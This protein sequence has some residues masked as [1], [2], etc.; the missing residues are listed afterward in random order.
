MVNNNIYPSFEYVLQRVATAIVNLY[1]YD[2]ELLEVDANERSITHKLAEHLQKEFPEWHVDCEYNRRGFDTKKLLENISFPTEN[3]SSDDTEARTV[4]PDIIVHKRTT[5]LN[6]LVIEVKK[7]NNNDSTIDIQKLM[8]F[9]HDQNYCY[10]FGLFVR[11]GNSGCKEVRLFEEGTEMQHE[12]S[13]FMEL[14]Q[15]NLREFGYGGE[16]TEM[17]IGDIAI[18]KNG[19]SLNTAFYS[20]GGRYPVWGANGQIARTDKILN[21]QPV[22]VVGRVGA[23]C[24]SVHIVHEPNWVTDN[25]IMVIPKPGN[26]INYLY[27]LMKH[28]NPRKTSIGSAQPLITQSGL[29]ILKHK[30]PP[31]PEQRAIAHILGILDDKIELNRRMNKT[32]EAMAQAL[33]K[34]WFVDFDPVV[35][36][37]LNAGNP[38]PEKFA[39]RAAWYGRGMPRP[40]KAL[41]L[42]DDIL[43]LFPDRFVESELGPI[44]E[45]WEATTIGVEFDL[46]MGQSPPGSTYN[47]KGEGL[48]FFQGRR[49]FGF[50]YPSNRVYCTAPTRIA[51]DG[52]TLVSV[53]APVGDI[54]MAYETCCVG[55]GVAAV[56]HKSGSRSYTY[57]AMR[58]LGERFKSYEAEG[59]VFGAIN[60]KQFQNLPSIAPQPQVVSIFEELVYPLDENIR[61]FEE[62]IR[63]LSGTHDT[64]LPKLISGELR[65]PDVEKILEGVE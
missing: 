59:T 11:L 61:S 65:V 44:P 20:G 58:A 4:F 19:K 9:G 3:N 29:K 26:D 52:D 40:D 34:S 39:E 5:P 6:L 43:R 25:A 64:L 60:K 53:R 56:R 18:L 63:I 13:Q 30:I 21:E 32:L 2:R 35:V 37:A 1:R 50:R 55:R 57:Y 48:P 47:E 33:F 7:D 28:L 54:N 41:G 36:N 49:D 51:H 62:E 17:S 15:E 45:G 8:A 12:A 10:R 22:I 27:Y 14:I 23:Y 42:P 46:T 24:G 16:W 38:I 31:L